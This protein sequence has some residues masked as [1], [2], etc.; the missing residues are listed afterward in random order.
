MG[1]STKPRKK[2]SKTSIGVRRREYL[3][4]FGTTKGVYLSTANMLA[5]SNELIGIIGRLKDNVVLTESDLEKLVT[6]VKNT[7]LQMESTSITLETVKRLVNK[8]EG[9]IPANKAGDLEVSGYYESLQE[10]NNQCIELQQNFLIEVTTVTLP[11]FITMLE[12][13]EVKE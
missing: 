13:L 1:T 5:K 4:S 2:K 3:E 9:K 7:V 11:E 12:N 6:T 10:I 8:V